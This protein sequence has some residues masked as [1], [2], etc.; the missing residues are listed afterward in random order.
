MDRPRGGYRVG[1]R[2]SG[3][4]RGVG[5][6]LTDGVPRKL[7]GGP[8]DGELRQSRWVVV[9][10]GQSPAPTI[11]DQKVLPIKTNGG[12]LCKLLVSGAGSSAIQIWWLTYAFGF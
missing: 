5:A 4:C 9:Y 10:R 3:L 2:G 6:F 11:F 8:G 12:H 7:P 1:C